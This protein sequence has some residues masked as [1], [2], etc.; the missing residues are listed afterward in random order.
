MNRPC[1]AHDLKILPEYFDAVQSGIKNFEIRKNDR[2]YKV[3]DILL[4]RE[5]YRGKYT[6]R[7][8]CKKVQYIYFGDG[9]YGLSAEYCILGLQTSTVNITMNGNN[10]TQIGF[11]QN[12]TM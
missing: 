9:T 4:L 10:S 7:Q 3:G 12:L 2:G 6:G 8:I 11:V 5:W 1:N